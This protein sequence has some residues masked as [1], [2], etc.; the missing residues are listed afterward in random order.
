[1]NLLEAVAAG[2]TASASRKGAPARPF[3]MSRQA[4]APR[5]QNGARPVP[6]RSAAGLFME[7][8]E[9]PPLTRAG[10]HAAK[11]G[12]TGPCPGRR[13]AGGGQ[14]ASAG[15]ARQTGSSQ[16]R[17]VLPTPIRRFRRSFGICPA[18]C[19]PK[20]KACRRVSVSCC[21]EQ[22]AVKKAYC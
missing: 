2:W 14:A 20:G 6:G 13:R 5:C 19:L 22:Y 12:K 15:T 18:A 11:A 9:R 3:G 21:M 8:G 17:L 4:H 10:V 7:A 1:M 16:G